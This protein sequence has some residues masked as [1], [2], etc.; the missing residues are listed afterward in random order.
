MGEV[1]NKNKIIIAFAVIAAGAVTWRHGMAME[2]QGAPAGAGQ[3]RIFKTKNNESV[4]VPEDRL[5]LF[6]TINDLL[7]DAPERSDIPVAQ[8][9]SAAL[10]KIVGDLDWVLHDVMPNMNENVDER[11]AAR[12]VVRAMP[13]VQYSNSTE[14]YLAIEALNAAD[15]LNQPSLV[16]RYAREVADMAM[17]GGAMQLLARGNNQYGAILSQLHDNMQNAI[18]YYMP[19][20]WTLQ[21]NDSI[22]SVAISADGKTVVTGSEDKT[23]KIVK[24]NGN[25]WVEQR[26]ITHDRDVTSVAISPDGN[27]VATGSCDN[28]AKILTRKDN[29][30]TE[31]YR[32]EHDGLVSLVAIS[33]D[34]KTVVTGSWDEAVKIVKWNGNTWTE[35]TIHE[36]DVHYAKIEEVTSVAISANGNTVVTGWEWN[37]ANIFEWKDNAWVE[38]HTIKHDH[39]V[40]SVAISADGKTVVTGSWDK[41]AK[42]VE[43]KNNA[44]VEQHTIKHN[45]TV[46][47]VAISADGNTVVTG[48][49][50]ERAKIVTRKGNAWA[51]Q[52][53]IN[54]DN[55]VYSVAISADG[56]RVVT[57]SAD[58]TATIATWDG[59]RWA[60]RLIYHDNSVYS[61]AI[62]ADGALVVTGSE[63]E[64]AKISLCLPHSLPEISDFDTRLF[65]H[66]LWWAKG[67][68]QKIAKTGWAQNTLDHIRWNAVNFVDKKILQA[69]IRETMEEVSNSNNQ[70]TPQV[71]GSKHTLGQAGEGSTKRTKQSED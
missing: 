31:Q 11:D 29:T 55:S 46:Y 66:L 39:P 52:H 59:S 56:N 25:T 62:S 47:S 28:T 16:E 18:L 5:I 21:H 37:R 10:K 9:S 26:T 4:E 8:F 6:G 44:W 48:S 45:D 20:F 58:D 23:A 53:T 40:D 54:H 70:R 30:W 42:I 12:T 3:V 64:T 35:H 65:E 27:T 43:W 49:G 34:G 22:S 71:S 41:T 63:D 50:D 38:Q 60:E 57:G 7:I 67:S 17:S 13:Q 24:W 2:Q 68:E 51:N 15:F 32:I 36:H 33:A 1:V 69:W 14:L 61:V 19:N